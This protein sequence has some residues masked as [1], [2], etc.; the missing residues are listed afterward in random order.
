MCVSA[1]Q[2]VS[3]GGMMG[4]S[5]WTLEKDSFPTEPFLVAVVQPAF[6]PSRSAEIISSTPK[7]YKKIQKAAK[8]PLKQGLISWVGLKKMPLSVLNRVGVN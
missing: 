5:I 4:L 2:R 7:T 3:W 1:K 8:T 6:K